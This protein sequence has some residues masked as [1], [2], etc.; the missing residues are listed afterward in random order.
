ML[1]DI[2]EIEGVKKYEMTPAEIL[3]KFLRF[4]AYTYDP[5]T[6]AIDIAQ[7]RS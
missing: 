5:I 1:D 6:N 4:Y 3:V 2:L 7:L